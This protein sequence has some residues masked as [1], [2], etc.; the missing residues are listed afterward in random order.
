[1]K[2][3]RQDWFCSRIC[4]S[5]EI[6][7][8]L[9]ILRRTARLTDGSTYEASRQGKPILT[10]LELQRWA[11]HTACSDT[12]EEGIERDD[13]DANLVSFNRDADSQEDAGGKHDV[14]ATLSK[15]VDGGDDGVDDTK[16]NGGGEEVT[17]EE[18]EVGN[19][20]TGKKGIEDFD[21]LP[22]QEKAINIM[23]T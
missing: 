2:N 21:C 23:I 19:A 4:P 12:R 1:M 17:E 9:G 3:L 7:K 5:E 10:V 16:G 11:K 6:S 22:E 18:E 20:K 13:D 15:R 14:R 8:T